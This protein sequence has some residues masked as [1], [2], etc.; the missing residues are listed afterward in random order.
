MLRLHFGI[1][2]PHGPH[3]ISREL[4]VF[5][6]VSTSNLFIEG[7]QANRLVVLNL[8]DKGTIFSAAAR[9]PRGRVSCRFDLAPQRCSRS[10][11]AMAT[12]MPTASRSLA[13][14]RI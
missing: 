2:G 3:V 10:P 9:N 8:G 5:N 11:N 4:V 7:P 1:D 6:W 12:T 13:R 14:E